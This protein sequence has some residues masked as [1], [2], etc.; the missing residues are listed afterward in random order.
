MVHFSVI[1]P[2]YNKEKFIEK[3]V[4]S[5]LNQTYEKFELI[6]IDDGSTDQSLVFLEKM[7]DKR[8]KVISQENQGVSIARNNGVKQAQHEWIAF[9]DADDWWDLNFLS[10]MN[11]L[12]QNYQKAAVF[13]SNYY[14]VKFGKNTPGNIGVPENFTV[15]YIN[16]YQVY[17]STL[18]VPVNCSFVVLRKSVFEN[19]GGF[20]PRLKFGEDFDLWLRLS[21][22]YSFAFLN[23][24]LAYSNQD[25][26]QNNRALG[27]KIWKKEEHVI[28]NLDYLKQYEN[29]NQDL[30]YLLDALR[31]R[32]LH[33]YYRNKIEV[34]SIR[35]ILHQ[36]D[37]SKHEFRY[38]FYYKYPF[39]ITK[40]YFSILRTASEIKQ[41]I[42]KVNIR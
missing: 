29:E 18:W 41:K 37:F 42:L 21:L 11:Q 30:K 33:V 32:S 38:K 22:N 15:G 35:E 24:Y 5:V 10:E 17:G 36:V 28:F 9:L 6:V 23:K 13:S 27:D 39:W 3:A 8:I 25:V 31:L 1:I 2:V 14:R 19:V 16:Y 40:L 26:P 12:I 4:D 7:N 34:E 20:D